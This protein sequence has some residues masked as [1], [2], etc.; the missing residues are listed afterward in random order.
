MGSRVG[1][2]REKRAGDRRLEAVDIL[3]PRQHADSTP[4]HESEPIAKLFP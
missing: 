4:V 3:A 2:Q 1:F